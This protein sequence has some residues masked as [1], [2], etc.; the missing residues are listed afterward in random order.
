MAL[1]LGTAF[2]TLNTVLVVMY[3]LRIVEAAMHAS[4]YDPALERLHL[5]IV[6]SRRR[7]ARP[8]LSGLV[9]RSG[10]ALG[11][12]LVLLLSFGLHVSLRQMLWLYLVVLLAWAGTVLTLRSPAEAAALPEPDPGTWK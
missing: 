9:A 8:V 7:L 10:E 2:L 6:E 1:S 5:G 3:V 4:L 12:V 11:A